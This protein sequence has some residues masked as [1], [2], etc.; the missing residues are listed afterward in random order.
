M[1]LN[2]WTTSSQSS[3]NITQAA[4]RQFL[5]RP[6]LWASGTGGERSEGWQTRGGDVRKGSGDV[7]PSLR[8]SESIPGPFLSCITVTSRR[9]PSPPR[10]PECCA[11]SWA[12]L[13]AHSPSPSCR[14]QQL[15]KHTPHSLASLTMSEGLPKAH[16]FTTS[17][18]QHRDCTVPKQQHHTEV[19]HHRR[20]RETNT[21]T[22]HSHSTD[23]PQDK[24]SGMQMQHREI[25]H[26]DF[27]ERRAPTQHKKIIQTDG[28]KYQSHLSRE[29]FGQRTKS[30]KPTTHTQNREINSYKS[31]AQPQHRETPQTENCKDRT[32]PQYRGITKTDIHNNKP[33]HRQ[34]IQTESFKSPAQPQHGETPQ[35]EN[36]KD[37]TQS[38]HRGITKNNKPQHRQTIKT[39]S[40]KCAAQPQKR[41]FSTVLSSPEHATV[42]NNHKP[43]QLSPSICVEM[44]A[45]TPPHSPTRHIFFSCAHLQLPAATASSLFYLPKPLIVCVG[46]EA[47][48]TTTLSL[49]LQRPCSSTSP[50][51]WHSEWDLSG[52]AELTSKDKRLQK[53][54]DTSNMGKS[55]AAEKRQQDSFR[56]HCQSCSELMRTRQRSG[57]KTAIRS[58]YSYVF[59]NPTTSTQLRSAEQQGGHELHSTTELHRT[60]LD[61]GLRKQTVLILSTN[62]QTPLSSTKDISLQD[63]LELFR[64]EFIMRSQSR[65]RRL[66]ERVRERQ[67]F[68]MDLLKLGDVMT[69]R[70]NCTRPHPLSDN[71]Y[72]PR[73]RTISGKEMQMRSKRIYNQLP[74]VTRKKEEEKK[75]VISET[76]RLRA[77]IFKKKLLDQIL[78]RNSD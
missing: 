22:L 49:R 58:V 66:Q 25:T 8:R 24:C 9:L 33:Q 16:S 63:A 18:L 23:S 42:Y 29:T 43:A 51:R 5:P 41:E 14:T 19:L 47:T 4:E 72:K 76:N 35:T 7:V 55:Q 69:Q 27:S 56:T 65:L 11:S 1:A 40:F 57:A 28:S 73:E 52:A 31:P 26:K 6:S 54:S 30:L 3:P 78:Q 61:S 59:S 44:V 62:G 2:H 48:H 20:S 13:A 68:Q 21:A 77:E 32:Q 60:E 75:R 67:A 36:C 45:H 38:Q 39:E 46:A 71:L 74:E 53:S 70:R 37:R 15:L 10:C 34:T 50:W 17:T 64:P 12:R